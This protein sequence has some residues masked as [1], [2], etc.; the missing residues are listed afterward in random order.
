V[1]SEAAPA[2]LSRPLAPAEAAGCLKGALDAIRAEWAG[3]SAAALG[4]HPAPGEW[5]AKE[6]LGHIIEA[7][8]RGFAGRIRAILAAAEPP[9]FTGWDQP[10][11]ARARRDCDKDGTAL[12]DEFVR[13]RQ[14]SVALAAGLREA[15]YARGGHHPTVGFLTI[16]DLLHEWVHH[17]RNHL[18]Q[19]LANVQAFVWPHMGNARKFSQPT[20]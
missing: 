19:L 5:C 9:R 16:G 11:V 18:K 4:Y 2:G 17:D 20:S 6:V 8:E 7:E 12:L 14:A 15:D 13:A 1:G 10:A 3:L